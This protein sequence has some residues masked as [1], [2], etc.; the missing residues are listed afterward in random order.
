MADKLQLR[1]RE[2]DSSV[3]GIANVETRVK[4]LVNAVI[5]SRTTQFNDTVTLVTLPSI[6]GMLPLRQFNIPGPID[7]IL[8]NQLFFTLLCLGRI[9]LCAQNIIIQ[10]TLVGWIVTGATTKQ[11]QVAKG[12]SSRSLHA[13]SLDNALTKFWEIEEIAERKNLS[14]EEQA[15]ENHFVENTV[16][17]VHGRYIVRLPFNDRKNFIGESREYLALGHMTEI[18]DARDGKEFYLPHH[19]VIKECSFTTKVKVVF[20]ASAKSSS[21]VSLND[22]LLVGPTIQDNL[23]A[24]LLRSVRCLQQLAEDE[25]IRFPNASRTF[26]EDFYVD[27][28]LTGASTFNEAINLRNELIDLAGNGG[29]QLHLSQTKKTLGVFWNPSSDSVT[30]AVNSFSET[31]LT[32]RLVLSQIAQLFDPL[33][34]LGPVIIR[35]KIIMQD[36]WKSK[37]T[38]DQPIP[39]DIAEVWLETRNELAQLDNFSCP[40]RVMLETSREIQLHGYCDASERTYGACIY[41]RTLDHSGRWIRTAPHLLK[42]F[43]ANRDSEIQT[44]SD[45]RNWMHVSGRDNPA[46]YISRG[47]LA[48]TFMNNK[49]WLNGPAWLSLD[50]CF[51]PQLDIPQ[52]EILERKTTIT[53]LAREGTNDLSKNRL[54]GNLSTTEIRKAHLVIIKQA[55]LE[56]FPIEINCLERKTAMP[57]G[58]RILNLNPF[59]DQDKLLRVGGRLRHAPLSYC[60]KHPLLLPHRH[61]ITN[62]IIESEHLRHWHAGTQATLNAVRQ[63]YWPIDGMR[64][65]KNVIHKCIRCFRVKPKVPAYIMGDLPKN[66]VTRARPFQ[67]VGVD[68]CGPFFIKEKKVRNRCKIKTYV[69]IFVCFVTKAVHLELTSDLT[70]ESCLGAFKRFFARRGKATNIYSDNGTNFVGAKN[71]ITEVQRFLSSNEHNSKINRFLSDQGINWHF[72]PPRSPHFGGLWEAAVKSFKGHLYKT[73]GNELFTFEQL[74]TYIIEV[75]AILNSR[76]LTPLSSDPNDLTALSPSHFLIGDSLMQLPEYDLRDTPVNKLSSWQHIQRVKQHFWNRWSNE[77]LQTLHTRNKW[78]IPNDTQHK[79]GTLVIIRED[80]TPPLTWKLGRIIDICPGRDK[81]VRVATVKTAQGTYQRAIKK[82]SPLP[83]DDPE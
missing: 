56:A 13:S 52:R 39:Q 49:V 45:P 48:S 72:S 67:N 74:N 73:I 44:D 33:G 30:Y 61:H 15:C 71:E 70:T 47:Q 69:A 66:R 59:L 37:V 9:K 57:K 35:A 80:N 22:A 23:W 17:D 24:I 4:Y 58:S 78:H 60:Q 16:R 76:P 2:I 46:D 27:D 8:G 21:G 18:S 6:T 42:T 34:L 5:K 63:I 53:F 64:A 54:T 62:L 77:Y 51:W 82:L 75:E 55:Q 25:Q 11:E 50:E 79:K 20:D 12:K 1:K 81:I 7:A 43:V 29:F 83:I 3:G 14:S 28:L 38:W 31:R 41:I 10:E 68:Y 26:K 32:K 19:A 65:T 36:I 40:R